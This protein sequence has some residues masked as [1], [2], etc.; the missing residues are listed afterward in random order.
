MKV[1]KKKIL[2]TIDSDEFKTSDKFEICYIALKDNL[3]ELNGNKSNLN[4]E[5][6]QWSCTKSGKGSVNDQFK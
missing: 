3:F 4:N 5:L 2:E 1:E 6:L